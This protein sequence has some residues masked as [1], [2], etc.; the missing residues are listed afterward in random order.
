M[1]PQVAAVA[2]L[3]QFGDAH[4]V[5]VRLGVLGPDVHGDLAEVEVGPDARG[6]G[7][8]R[9]LQ[10]VLDDPLGQLPGRETV[11]VQVA[12]HVHQHLVD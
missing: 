1:V 4:A 6:G 2:L 5:R 8:A 11:G 3:V 9:G 10:H 12:R 7:D